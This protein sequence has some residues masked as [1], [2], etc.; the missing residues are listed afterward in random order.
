[1]PSGGRALCS[2]QPT[3]VSLVSWREQQT[4]GNCHCYL[5]LPSSVTI[6]TR[7]LNFGVLILFGSANIQALLGALY[8]ILVTSVNHDHKYRGVFL[9][10][11]DD[12]VDDDD[13]D[14]VER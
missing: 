5:K 14:Q 3:P 1:M 4:S 9:K 8:A 13:G 10:P 7:H 12:D 11:L 2:V 6:T